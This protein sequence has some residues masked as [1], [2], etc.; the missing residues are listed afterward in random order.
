MKSEYK[1]IILYILKC[2]CGCLIVFLISW[3]INYNDI[4]WCMISVILVI[5][6]DSD[7][8]IPLAITRIK[9]NIIGGMASLLCFLIDLPIAVS[10]LSAVVITILACYFFKLMSGSRAAIA[11]VII[12]MLHGEQYNQPA[13]WSIT[14][15]RL[16]SVIAGCLIALIVTF[17]FHKGALKKSLVKIR[18]DEG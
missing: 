5:T 15:Q 13:F 10:I 9:A 11:A 17:L 4:S 16:I 3:W 8:S 1:N 12:I 6:P 14:F 7:E 2:L 18:Q